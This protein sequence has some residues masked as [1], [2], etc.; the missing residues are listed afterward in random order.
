[1]R[2]TLNRRRGALPAALLSA[3]ALAA[4][5]L[6]AAV[7]PANAVITTPGG[8]NDQDV[9]AFYRDAQGLALQLCV[10]A[11]EARCEPPADGH[12][13]V[14]FAA[15]ATAGP[16]NA[17]YGVEA[18]IDE[19]TGAPVVSN[20]ARFRFTAA[21]PNTTYRIRDPWGTTN[22]RTD[23]T[24][25]ADCRL[26]TSGAFGAVRA[27]HITTFLRSVRN[28]GGLFIGNADLPSL[29]AGSPSGFNR[30]TVT[31]GGR[32][33]RT[34]RFA[35]MGEKRANTPM[36]SVSTRAL[37]LG[38]PQRAEPVVRN[39]RYA[40]FGTANARPTVRIGGQNPG[41]FRVRNTCGSQAPGSACNFV[42]TFRPRQNVN[43][44]ARAV[45]TIDDNSLAAPRQ[46]R[47][48]GVGLRR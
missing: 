40:S 14:Y 46:V 48:R 2:I 23:A 21:R 30:I 39:I 41:A 18:A 44:T 24:G 19:D 35:V 12:I 27:G 20:G 6:V 25:G 15:D 31:G 28:P 29:V 32:T 5:G 47:L 11:N 17:I 43:R 9:P 13:G 45:L 10:D 8:L 1:M 22:C 3:A 34:N 37:A 36:S 4:S 26:E 38:R 16:M 33:F 42:V 7:A